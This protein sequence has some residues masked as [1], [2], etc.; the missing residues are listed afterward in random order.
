MQKS[1][2]V[3][4]EPLPYWQEQEKLW[5]IIRDKTSQI[6]VKFMSHD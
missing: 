5:D 6:W 3:D 4:G 2:I 1:D